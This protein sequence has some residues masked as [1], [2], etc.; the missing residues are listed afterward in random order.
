VVRIV[1]EV[2]CAFLKILISGSSVLVVE[3][4]ESSRFLRVYFRL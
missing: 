2:L 1:L 3:W 4:W